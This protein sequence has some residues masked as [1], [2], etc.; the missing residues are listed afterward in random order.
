MKFTPVEKAIGISVFFSYLQL[1]YGYVEHA[2][3]L[4]LVMI[5][6]VLLG[7]MGYLRIK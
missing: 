6:F 7:I 5:L 1:I 2:F 3:F 4:L